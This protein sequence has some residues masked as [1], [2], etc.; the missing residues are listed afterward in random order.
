MNIRK[1]HTQVLLAMVLGCVFGL[2]F[3]NFDLAIITFIYKPITMMGTIFVRLL[4][5]V[6][7]P[8][9]F[10]SIIIGVSSIGNG[11]KIGRIGLKTF[12]YYMFTSLCAIVIGLTLCNYINVIIKNKTLIGYKLN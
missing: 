12:F 5:M 1:L 3:K 10:T 2:I 7:V 6:M 9:I 4:K 8:L 11:K